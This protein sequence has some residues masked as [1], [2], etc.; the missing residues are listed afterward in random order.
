[1]YE[2]GKL[3]VQYEQVNVREEDAQ[4]NVY[5]EVEVIERD[6]EV[7][8]EQ[9][10]QQITIQSTTYEPRIIRAEP[11]VVRIS[12]PQVIRIQQPQVI[13]TEPQII[14]AEPQIIRA[15]PQVIHSE[16]ARVYIRQP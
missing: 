9:P 4:G 3:V 15:E 11:E 7:V 12:E 8:R 6:Y 2:D 16:P 5:E 10:Q 1:M 13:R 14:R